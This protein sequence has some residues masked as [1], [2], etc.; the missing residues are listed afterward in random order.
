[1]ALLYRLASNPDSA[2]DALKL[3]HELQAHQVELDLQ[4]AQIEANEREFGEDLIH[5]KALYDLAPAGYFIVGLEGLI[6]DG[7]RAAAK[8]LGVGPAD[9]LNQALGDFLLPESRPTFADLLKTLREGGA[10]ASC[11]VRDAHGSNGAR[12]LWISANRSP[13][14]E[15]LLMLVCEHDH[16]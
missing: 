16:S 1:L 5:Y 4:Q 9:F 15:V 6:I 8:L 10:K 13:D 2:G 14:S 7:N 11:E 3:L 12:P